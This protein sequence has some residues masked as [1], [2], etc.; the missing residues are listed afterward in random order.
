M[1]Q[2]R[3]QRVSQVVPVPGPTGG[4]DDTSSIA[5]MEPKFAVDMVNYFPQASDIRVRF[6]Y[7]EWAKNLP[8]DGKT[9]MS[10]NGVDGTSELFVCTDDGIYDVTAS[11]STPTLVHALTEGNVR[12]VQFGNLS[13]NWLVGCNGVDAAF[14]YNGTAWGS[15]VADA[16][17]VNPGEID[18]LAP[19]SI[20]DVHIHKN[21]LWFI[22]ANTLD[23]YYFPTNAMAGTAT[24]FPLGGIFKSGGYLNDVFSWTL[25]AGYSVDDV[26]VFQTSRGELAGYGGNDPDVLGDWWLE[27]RY[28][29]GAPLGTKTN[30]ELNGDVL[31]L[32]AYGLVPISK[33]VSGQYQMGSTEG[34]VSGRISRTLNDLVRARS[35]APGWS[36][37]ASPVH[38]YIIINF[39]TV[40]SNTPFQYVM[41]S[42]T[43]AWTR[44]DFTALTFHEHAGY[45]YFTDESNR[46]LRYGTTFLD[47]VLIDGTGGTAITAGFQQAYNY[48]GD[49][50]T[51]KHYK[52]IRPIF[53]STAFPPYLLTIS[54]DYAPGG[55]ESLGVPPGSTTNGSAWDLGVW[56]ESIWSAAPTAWQEWVGVVD[57]GYSASLIVKT[58]TTLDTSFVAAH[59]AF[60]KGVSL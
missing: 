42:V 27:A 23:A 19:A 4:I 9:L 46:V 14:F 40:A 24:V 18:G 36:I 31:M 54:A 13:G 32:T 26:L 2:P 6:G 38:Q 53:E 17:P 29:V 57:I 51:N 58:K 34:T 56:D 12:W 41:N 20:T 16:T 52:L 10:Y 1:F 28:F 47:N 44:F 15:F 3:K 22:E 30:V 35:G 50:T 59:W 33:V 55:I 21:R 37:H 45:L 7:Q 5:N 8:S 48:F 43:G 49:E 25:D 11:T 39:P 60:E